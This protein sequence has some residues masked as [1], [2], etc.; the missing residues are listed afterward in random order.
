MLASDSSDPET[1]QVL[2][3][4]L[5][6]IEFQQNI[7]IEV[8]EVSCASKL[9]ELRTCARSQP[10]HSQWFHYTASDGKLGS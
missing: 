9:P 5:Q 7:P 6:V 3:R 10:C 8:L 1:L 2:N 4:Q